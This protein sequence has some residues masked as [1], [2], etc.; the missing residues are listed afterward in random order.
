MSEPLRHS[1]LLTDLYE[2]TMAA[3]Y[4]ENDFRATASFEL[5]VRSLPPERSFLLTAGLEQALDYLERVQFQPEDIE[6]LRRQPVFAHVSDAF[7][8]YLRDFRFTGEVWA[9]P[10]GTPVFGEQPLLRVTAPILEAQIVETFLLSTMLFQTS[11]AT[12]AA[13]VVEAAAGRGVVEFGTRRAHG[14]EAGVLAAR[15]A[16]VGGCI[17]TSNVEAGQRF[18]IPVFGTLAHSFVMAYEDEEEAFQRFQRLFPD[19]AVLLVD[20]YDTLAAIEKII[21]AGLRPRSVRLDSGDLVRLSQ[22]VRRRLDQAGLQD[23]QIFA[24]GDLDE[25]AIADLLAAGAQV[26]AFG[27]GTALATSKDAPALGGVYKLVDVQSGEGPSY[28]AKFSE[29]KVTYPGRKQVFRFHDPAGTYCEDVIARETERYP[30]AQP[31]LGCVMRQG[32]RLA[33]SPGLKSVQERAREEVARLPQACRSL[34]NPQA[35]PVR[36]S[37]ELERLL[38]DVRDRLADV[39]PLPPPAKSG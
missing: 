17:G 29:E 36:F 26:D 3:A 34:R 14:P 7:F 38:N 32:T 37:G 13:R 11:I 19:H 23:T 21:H 16:F 22:Q 5:Y 15:A 24:S 8:D 10:E 6:Y 33:P 20:T 30:D 2:L 9:V 18:G 28:R 31:L 39:A 1:A 25:F 4:F 35:Y 12:K 27:V